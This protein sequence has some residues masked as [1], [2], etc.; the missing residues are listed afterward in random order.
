M[1]NKIEDASLRKSIREVSDT[2]TKII[3]TI[4]KN[5]KKAR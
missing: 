3:E 1:V 2:I 5:P 4:E